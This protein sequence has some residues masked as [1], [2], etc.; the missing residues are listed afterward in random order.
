MTSQETTGVQAEVQGTRLRVHSKR[1]QLVQK[2]ISSVK[3]KLKIS[4]YSS[5]ILSF[6]FIAIEGVE[7]G[8]TI[9]S[10]VNNAKLE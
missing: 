3:E 5:Y 2:V 9:Y 8:F 4:E 7:V 1:G 6:L 10:K